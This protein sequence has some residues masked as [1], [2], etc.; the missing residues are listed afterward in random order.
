MQVS[1]EQLRPT[2]T[3]LAFQPIR[4]SGTSI[5]WLRLYASPPRAPCHHLCAQSQGA[6]GI[7][8]AGGHLPPVS[9]SQA[10]K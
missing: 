5:S 6:A 3:P 10:K 1:L 7:M 4:S 2:L 9:S 8:P